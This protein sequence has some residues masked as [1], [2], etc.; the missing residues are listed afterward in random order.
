MGKADAYRE[1]LKTLD[2]WDEFL[3]RESGLPG[4]RVIEKWLPGDDKDVIWIMKQNLRK[5]RLIRLDAEWGEQWKIKLGMRR[6]ARFR[7]RKSAKLY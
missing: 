5:K 7:A 2:H 6:R 1:A 3:L 4:K